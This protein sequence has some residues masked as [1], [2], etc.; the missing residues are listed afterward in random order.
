MVGVLMGIRFS[1]I[2]W[3]VAGCRTTWFGCRLGFESLQR[4]FAM[5]L[6]TMLLVSAIGLIV[7]TVLFPST[8]LSATVFCVAVYGGVAGM[9][10]AF[11]VISESR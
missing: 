4:T 5:V 8:G 2:G 1:I 11:A 10:A 3:A 6:A 7:A 9:V